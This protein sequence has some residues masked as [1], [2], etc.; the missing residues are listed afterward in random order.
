MIEVDG[1]NPEEVVELADPRG[2]LPTDR[3]GVRK[4][5]QRL[6]SSILRPLSQGSVDRL[7]DCIGDQ[8]LEDMFDRGV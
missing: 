8:A 1:F 5:V 7:I 4:T 6:R 2:L 3:Q